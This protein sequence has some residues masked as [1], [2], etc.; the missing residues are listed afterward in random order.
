[1]GLSDVKAVA[2]AE[3]NSAALKKDGTVWAWGSNDFGNLG[4]G[5]KKESP[6]P[7]RVAKLTDV[8]AI[9]IG[10]QHCLALK[11]DGTVWG[12]GFGWGFNDAGVFDAGKCVHRLTPIKIAG[13]ADVKAVEAGFHL[14][15]LKKD[16]TLWTWGEN[17]DGQLGYASTATSCFLPA[18]VPEPDAPPDAAPAGTDNVT[19]G[20]K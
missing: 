20:A 13:L 10:M 6:V 3:L 9:S 19:P 15:V 14:A 16:G 8:V 2:A 18:R 11:S 5:S 7:V 4:N 17:R 12:W 1:V